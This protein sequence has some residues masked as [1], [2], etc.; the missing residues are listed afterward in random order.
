MERAGILTGYEEAWLFLASLTLTHGIHSSMQ[1]Q[2]LIKFAKTDFEPLFCPMTEQLS[3]ALSV[4]FSSSLG[5]TIASPVTAHQCLPCWHL[6][7]PIL[8]QSGLWASGCWLSLLV[9]F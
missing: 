9:D 1:E 3:Y 2:K 6:A 5:H 4:K 7:V 8:S